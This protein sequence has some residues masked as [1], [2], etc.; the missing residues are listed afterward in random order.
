MAAQ[1]PST[2]RTSTPSPW[3]RLRA[4]IA[5][6]TQEAVLFDES[7]A[8]NI[9]LGRPGASLAEIKAAARDAAA[10]DFIRGHAGRL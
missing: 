3:N 8:Y 1:S 4:A 5:V 6:V 7:V 10:H 2:D 9:A